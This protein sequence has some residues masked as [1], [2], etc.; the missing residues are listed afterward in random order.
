MID[1]FKVVLRYVIFFLGNGTD[2]MVFGLKVVAK[3]C[4][5]T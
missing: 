3:L 4:S 5:H 2:L 1:Y